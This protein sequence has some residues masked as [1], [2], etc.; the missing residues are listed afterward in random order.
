MA[1]ESFSKLQVYLK[2]STSLSKLVST[3][4]SSFLVRA[5]LL[6]TCSDLLSPWSSR[7]ISM[8]I[9]SVRHLSNK[10]S[11]TL[12]NRATASNLST[13]SVLTAATTSSSSRVNR[14]SIV[15]VEQT[16]PIWRSRMTLLWVLCLWGTVRI[17]ASLSVQAAV[18]SNEWSAIL[19]YLSIISIFHTNHIYLIQ[20]SLFS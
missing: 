19:S 20:L 14:P 8:S 4:R 18:K 10:S 5:R 13:H 11:K 3:S 17:P 7:S 12:H 15:T 6:V 1:S 16:R 9:Q 2:E